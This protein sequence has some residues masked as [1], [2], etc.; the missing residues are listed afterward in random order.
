MKTAMGANMNIMDAIQETSSSVSFLD[1]GEESPI[2]KA[3]LGETQP[4]AVP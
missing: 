4:M 3:L 2:N 1:E